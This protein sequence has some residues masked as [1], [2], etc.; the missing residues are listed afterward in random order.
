MSFQRWCLLFGT[1]VYFTAAWFGVGYSA[2]DEFQQVILVAEHL[3]GNVDAASLPLDIHA[4]WRSMVQPVICAAVFEACATIGITDPFLLTLLLRLLTAALAIRVTHGFVRAVLPSIAPPHQRAFILLSWFL[5]FLPVLQVRFS[6]EAW[7]GLLFLRGITMLLQEG[8]R[9]HL[10]IGAWFGAAVLFRP[11]V[12]LLPFGAL[13]WMVLAQRASRS[14]VVSVMGGGIAVVLCGAVIDGLAYGTPVFT[15]WNYALAG[16]TGEEAWRFTVLPWYQYPLFIIK[17]AAPPIGL[18]MLG[19]FVA[20]LLWKPKHLLLWIILPFLLVH[21]IL[22][23]KEIRFL[24][25]LAPLVPWLLISAWELISERWPRIAKSW[26]TGTSLGLVGAL[27]CVALV[28]AVMTPAGNGRIALAEEIHQQYG[29][30]PVHIAID[31]DWRFWVPAFFLAPGS[32]S[33]FKEQPLEFPATDGRPQLIITRKSIAA[34]AG[35]K[36]LATS[37]PAWT[38]VFFR[39]YGLEDGYDPLIVH[40]A[41]INGE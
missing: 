19:A 36:P 16:V 14:A 6:G 17:Y 35:L 12:A 8:R 7:S 41:R 13:L 2:E 18:L 32:T 37:T 15:L 34:K 40:E 25:P 1:V 23:I 31:G 27:N 29:D 10:A 28:V 30:Q 38:H 33:A 22:P 3:R 26:I 39:W 11:A 24:F 5:W 4:Q 21:S 20:L 9:K